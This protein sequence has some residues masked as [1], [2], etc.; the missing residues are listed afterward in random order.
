MNSYV[1]FRELSANV[2]L[3]YYYRSGD[4]CC[5]CIL[6]FYYRIC[7]YFND[8]EYYKG[9]SKLLSSILAFQKYETQYEYEN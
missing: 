3:N 8:C 2:V 9:T 4:C 7:M 1:T 5:C 6:V